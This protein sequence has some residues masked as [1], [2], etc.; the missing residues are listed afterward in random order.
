MFC[1]ILS[2]TK[3]EFKWKILKNYL[4]TTLNKLRLSIKCFIQA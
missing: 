2:S 1:D 3:T 4:Y